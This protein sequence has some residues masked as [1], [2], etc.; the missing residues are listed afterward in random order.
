MVSGLWRVVSGLGSVLSWLL[1]GGIR[2][3]IRALK[4]RITIRLGF[5]RVVS[6]RWSGIRPLEGSTVVSG[7]WK[8]LSGLWRVVSDLYKSF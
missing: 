4:G 2:S 3:L 8:V 5:W 7:L 1:E 6:G